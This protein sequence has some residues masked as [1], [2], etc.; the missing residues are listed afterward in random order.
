MCTAAGYLTKDFYFGRN[1]D[2]EF[3]YGEKVTITPRNYVF[4]FRRAG[5]L[6]SHFAII[7]MAYV[8]DSYPLYYDGANEKGLC[9]AGLNF[10]GNAFYQKELVY[11]P[12]K[13]QVAQ[14]EFIPWI[15]SQCATVEE[16]KRLIG[17]M[18]LVDTPFSDRLPSASLHWIISDRNNSIVVESM[19][20]GLHVYDNPVGVLTNNPPFPYQMFAL[21]NHPEVSSSQPEGRFADKLKVDLY[22]RGMG[23]LGIPGDLSSQSRFIRVAFAKLGSISSDDEL[24]SVSQF[25]HILQMVEQPRGLCLVREGEY[26][27]T[28]YTSCINADLGIYYYKTYDNSQINAVDMHH[29][30]LDSAELISYPIVS[31]GKLV[32]QN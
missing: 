5:V 9:M 13:I 29:V 7:G 26:E 2:Y 28:I 1:L 12:D 8:Q 15:L 14:F 18:R 3:S 21:N 6:N 17:R 16:A 11:C 23:G 20:D 22:S 4:S 32:F 24:S 27:I 31:K 10:V 25:F 19:K 30:D